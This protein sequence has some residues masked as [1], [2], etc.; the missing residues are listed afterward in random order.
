DLLRD[1]VSV[2]DSLK[3]I[4][5]SQLLDLGAALI[6]VPSSINTV[7]SL[8]SALRA[9][10]T[11]PVSLQDDTLS[12]LKQDVQL[13][14]QDQQ[15]VERIETL[16]RQ[17]LGSNG[18]PYA[19][20]LGDKTI[21]QMLDLIATS[22]A[23]SMSFPQ[24]AVHVDSLMGDYTAFNLLSDAADVV[25][26]L[27]GNRAS[28]EAVIKLMDA[29]TLPDPNS[30]LGQLPLA[31]IFDLG[32]LLLGVGQILVGSDGLQGVANLLAGNGSAVTLINLV[33][34]AVTVDGVIDAPS[35]AT[36]IDVLDRTFDLD[37]AF[38]GQY[39][40]ADLIADL[41][42]PEPSLPLAPMI[43]L[44]GNALFSSNSE[45]SLAVDV[46]GLGLLDASDRIIDQIVVVTPMI[47]V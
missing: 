22:P 5:L 4:N 37:R 11:L 2:P 21:V 19:G 18:T 46:G 15:L 10:F 42:A 38:E 24:L 6:N 30:A 17:V 3:A 44:G 41:R 27:W 8:L 29:V 34:N 35:L 39:D 33:K 12:S 13:S 1:T 31:D 25:N 23:A 9:N 43:L 32:G 40:V 7:G 16:A 47:P 36:V 20:S 14:T 45:L 28:G 26:G